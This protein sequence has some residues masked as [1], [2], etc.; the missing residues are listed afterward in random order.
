M[1]RR[2][3]QVRFVKTSRVPADLADDRWT[4]RDLVFATQH[5]TELD[6]ANVRRAFRTVAAKAGLTAEDWTPRELRHGLVSLL[7]SRGRRSRP[8]RTWPGT[9]ARFDG[10]TF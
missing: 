3:V 10:R 5:R 8:S 6:A 2:G 1:I 7:S 9:R 4:D